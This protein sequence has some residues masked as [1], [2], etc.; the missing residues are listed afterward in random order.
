[1]TSR[2]PRRYG[3]VASWRHVRMACAAAIVAALGLGAAACTSAGQSGGGHAVAGGVVTFAEQPADPPNYIFPLFPL[4]HWD[5]PNADQMQPLLYRPLYFFGSAS[6]TPAVNAQ[7]SLADPPVYSDGNRTV[8]IT[9]K[10]YA[11]SDGKPVTSRDVEFWIDMLRYNPTG[12]GPYVPGT[13]PDDV[14][15]A[16]YPNATTVVLHLNQAY[17]PTWFTNWAL[18]L[19]TPMP[20]HAWD[21]T[22][23]SGA[24][25]NYDETKSG[26]QAVYKF[27]NSQ[28]SD[29]STFATN[30]LWQTVDGPWKLQQLTTTG[31]AV[32]VPNK[33]YSGP[34]KPRISEFVEL[35][36]TSE[37]AEY[38]AVRSGAVDY[39]YLPF[40]D[41]SQEA[42]LKQ[43]GYQI[44]PWPLF[45]VNYLYIDYGSAQ[46]GAVFKQ[47]YIRQ[48]MQ[49]LINQPQ[50]VSAIYNNYAYPTYGPV[51][52]S[53][54]NSYA[55]AN[56]KTNPYPYNPKLASQL[57]TAHGWTQPAGGGPR[58]C[59]VPAE[60][61][62]GIAKGTPLKFPA[63]YPSGVPDIESMMQAIQSNFQS[64]G[65]QM[66]ANASPTPAIGGMLG[67][68]CK[69]ANCWGLIDYDTAFYFQPAAFPDGG[70]PF[71]TG[72]VYADGYSDPQMNNLIQQV[73][74]TPGTSAI[75]AYE[76]YAAK[77]LPGLWIPQPYAQISVI[78]N[79]LKG[80]TPQNVIGTNITPEDWYLTSG[81]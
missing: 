27:L 71:G 63:Y 23:A 33:K 77:Q 38:N 37:V 61:G 32:F 45:G 39:G 55:S 40:S 20:Q 22:S 58:V 11:W 16:D 48:A 9:L 53:P 4:D 41:V 35:P 3:S 10:P 70:P 69:S 60:C 26:A 36:F 62:P 31:K 67:P 21:K 81:S 80:A 14:Q 50:I 42:S 24:V 72:A 18:A 46:M 76:S 47:L 2:V 44:S 1:M 30:P 17:N 57:L 29:P 28:S 52:V 34:D 49:D 66:T 13:F 59:S 68:T 6:G 15:S 56:E 12:Y 54:P 65:I 19:I 43:Q 25:G 64:A 74:S 73:R 78:K 5:V 8:T 75:D 7:K 51:P 79:T